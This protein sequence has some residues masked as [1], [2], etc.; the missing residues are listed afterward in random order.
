MRIYEEL[1]IVDPNASDEDI[2]AVSTQ[3]QG[4]IND[5]GGTID[6]VDKWGKRKLA[7]RVKKREEGF[8]ILV[9]FTANPEM[10]KEIER[11]LRVHDLV[12]KYLTVRIDEKLQWLDKRKKAR[13]KRAQK[14]PA[15]P[16]A[17]AP[18]P[19]MP[20]EPIEMESAAVPEEKV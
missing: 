7:Y 6:K 2:D 11:R 14:K 5:G 1:F 4:V 20:G 18:G 12:L 9:Q 8:Y 15:A 3:V 10:V 17:A 13:E 19:R 16:A